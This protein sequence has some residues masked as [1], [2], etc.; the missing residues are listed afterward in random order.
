MTEREYDVDLTI[1][2]LGKAK[3]SNP[4]RLT[5]F[6]PEDER[7]ICETN[8]ALIRR[9]LAAAHAF[10]PVFHMS[11]PPRVARGPSDSREK[12]AGAG[13]AGGCV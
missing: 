5:R 8:P 4:M 6:T 7:V 3:V 13:P 2:R 10:L 11:H 12:D 1:D 9:D